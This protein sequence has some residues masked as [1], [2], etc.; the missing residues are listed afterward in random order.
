MLISF[1]AFFFT[2]KS[3]KDTIILILAAVGLIFAQQRGAWVGGAMVLVLN[4]VEKIKTGHMKIK[5]MTL[6]RGLV[7]IILGAV[8]IGAGIFRVDSLTSRYEDQLGEQAI[9]ER[10]SQWEDGLDNM[11]KYPFGTG[12]GQV[13]QVSRV[14]SGWSPFNPCADGDYPRI[15][16]ETGVPGLLFYLFL[17]FMAGTLFFYSKLDL[18]AVKTGLFVFIGI[19]AQMI[20]SNVTE[21]FFVNFLYWMFIGYMFSGMRT[22]DS[23]MIFT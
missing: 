10:Q 21:F 16:S 13:G 19:S 15:F 4:F 20:G 2:N 17:F 12:V 22:E 7:I 11:I 23:K 3:I 18:K 1:T 6:I 5:Q 14:G 8:L 9:G